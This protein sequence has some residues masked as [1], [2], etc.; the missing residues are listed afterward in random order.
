MFSNWNDWKDS[1][2]KAVSPSSEKT[3][4]LTP[5][6]LLTLC[7]D[8][9]VKSPLCSCP[10]I[11]NR[12]LLLF[13]R[14]GGVQ[15]ET[16]NEHTLSS[17]TILNRRHEAVGLQQPPTNC[18]PR[19]LQ[20][21]NNNIV[22]SLKQRSVTQHPVGRGTQEGRDLSGVYYS[23]F[24]MFQQKATHSLTPV[25]TVAEPKRQLRTRMWNP[26]PSKKKRNTKILLGEKQ[27]IQST[28]QKIA[29]SH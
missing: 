26:D 18:P 22:L 28:S 25:I 27:S 2:G 17:A 9:G 12:D 10:H 13:K 7:M 16:A 4:I 19:S 20:A 29:N 21:L 1:L 6:P 3:F 11:C 23:Y 8:E 15:T 5:N 14:G 24:L